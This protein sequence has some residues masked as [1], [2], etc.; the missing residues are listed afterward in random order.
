MQRLPI[1]VQSFRNLREEDNLYVD[2]TRQIYDL[3]HTGKFVFL[4]RPRRFGK[5]LLTT[6]LQ[7]IFR[8]NKVLFEG[9]WIEDKIDWQPR[10]VILINFNDLDYLSQSLADA[11]TN[12]MDELAVAQDIA[13]TATH[14]KD[15]FRELIVR[16]STEKTV[17]ILIDEYDKAITD[18]FENDE[19][20]Q[21]HVATL[22]NFYSV[23]KSTASDHL[24]FVFL[25]GVSKYGKVSIFSDLNN[26]LDITL[27]PRFATLLGYTQAELE[28]YFPDRLAQLA[29]RY[30]LSLPDMLTMIARW[31]NGYSWDGVNTVYVPFSTLVFLEQ[32]MFANHWFATATPSF[33][34]KLL[35]QQQIPPYDLDAVSADSK[36]LDSA[37]VHRI[38][39]YSLLFQ[40]GYL[41]VKSTWHGPTGQE[42]ELGYPNFEV[43]QAFQQHLLS[44]YL[45]PSLGQ[46]S[47]NLIS[48]LYKVLLT[49]NIEG[50]VNILKS[51]F[52]S[53]P[54]TLFLPQEAY[55]H[56]LV[57]LLMKL[58]GFTVYAEPLT[59]L[60]RI[61]AVL[62]LDEV[63]YVIEFKMSTADIALQQIRNKQYALPFRNQGKRIILLGLAF[64]AAS[65]NLVDW[66]MAE[67][68]N[69]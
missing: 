10:P 6:T 36:L 30:D 34:I 54:H 8:G 25:T 65:R 67:D 47:S 50:F 18:L 11:L 43:A 33:L 21:E 15:K 32:Q 49:Q 12:Y 1:G 66:Q 31:Y 60:G 42:Y 44:D 38:N 45:A 24:H 56:S 41:T 62:A 14:Y 3:L 40:T 55:Y 23:L 28:H 61:D 48:R 68:T 17:A 58:L 5:S 19:K 69:P 20:V 39:V 27:D 52:A 2:K 29:Q 35:R 46:M 63:V 51:I 16:L 53:I 22:K 13:L 59:N 37:D 64:D 9:L 26:L 4:S 7:E 57:Y